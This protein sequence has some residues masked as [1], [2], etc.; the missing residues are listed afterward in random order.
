[1]IENVHRAQHLA[2]SESI[3]GPNMPAIE[4]IGRILERSRAERSFKRGVDAIDVH[5]MISSFRGFRVAN[6]HTLGRKDRS[7]LSSCT[8]RSRRRAGDEKSAP[9]LSIARRSPAAA[10]RSNS[11]IVYSAS[12]IAADS[13][14][15]ATIWLAQREATRRRRGSANSPPLASAQATQTVPRSTGC[16]LRVDWTR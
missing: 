10:S 4:I 1:M 2:E 13:V 5:M 8:G 14:I 15:S 12:A 7:I 16:V 9:K 3:A 11:G 6:R